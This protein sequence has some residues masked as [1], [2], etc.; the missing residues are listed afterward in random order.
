MSKVLSFQDLEKVY[1]LVAAAIDAAGPDQEA[2]FLSKLCITLAHNIQD[3][4][5][6]E[7]AIE[8]ARLDLEPAR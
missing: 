2:L 4:S 8:I 1:D 3:I 7:E 6:I 5:I